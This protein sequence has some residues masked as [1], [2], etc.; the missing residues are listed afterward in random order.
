MKKS[1]PHKSTNFRMRRQNSRCW[2]ISWAQ[3][4]SLL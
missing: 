3:I 4:H 1:A 2:L